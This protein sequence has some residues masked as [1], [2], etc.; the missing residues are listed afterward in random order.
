MPTEDICKSLVLFALRGE[1]VVGLS[2]LSA[3]PVG[4]IV[5]PYCSIVSSLAAIV[6]LS[7]L[8]SLHFPQLQRGKSILDRGITKIS[9][10][11]RSQR[12]V[13]ITLAS[14]LSPETVFAFLALL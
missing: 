2:S 7:L 1:N 10:E 12:S 11:K 5:A 8:F 13:W 9:V 14:C 4:Q 6:S 3:L